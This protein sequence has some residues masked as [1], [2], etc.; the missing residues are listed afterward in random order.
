MLIKETIK[1]EVDY[2]DNNSLLNLYEYLS[3]LKNANIANDY[4]KEENITLKSVQDALS[5]SKRDWAKDF[6]EEREE[7][8]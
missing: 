4:K 6:T 5:T 1:K 2:L 8:I 7:R 3:I